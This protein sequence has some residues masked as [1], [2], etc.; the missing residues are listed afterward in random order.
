MIPREKALDLILEFKE[1]EASISDAKK[2]ALKA[3]Q[4]MLDHTLI[5]RSDYVKEKY[6]IYWDDVKQFIEKL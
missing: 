6:L 2:N 3:I 4:I 1:V 5:I